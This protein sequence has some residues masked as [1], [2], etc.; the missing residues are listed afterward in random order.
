MDEMEDALKTSCLFLLAIVIATAS[1][2]RAHDGA[3]PHSHG[4][5]DPKPLAATGA[6]RAERTPE[7]VA[8]MP[9]RIE[10]Q[11]VRETEAREEAAPTRH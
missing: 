10:G 4:S 3:A 5:A 9:G 6:P 7:E 2:V 11:R 8:A 1:D